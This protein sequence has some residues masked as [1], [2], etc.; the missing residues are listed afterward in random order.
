MPYEYRDKVAWVNPLIRPP[1][2]Q[3]GCQDDH[4]PQI[5]TNL[6]IK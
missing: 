2:K 4:R 3:L 5:Y 1:E 6:H